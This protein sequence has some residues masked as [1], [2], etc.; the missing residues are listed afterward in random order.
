[1]SGATKDRHGHGRRRRLGALLLV[2]LAGCAS[3][4]RPLTTPTADADARARLRATEEQLARLEQERSQSAAELA[5]LEKRV[6]GQREIETVLEE[7]VDNL[8]KEND[9]LHGEL[10]GVVMGASATRS[11][12]PGLVNAGGSVDPLAL[13]RDLEDRLRRFTEKYTAARFDPSENVCRFASDTLFRDGGDELTATGR[14]MLEELAQI[15]NQ[16]SAKKFNLSIVGHTAVGGPLP[17]RLVAQHPTEWHLA[18]HQ[19]IAVG[20][21]LEESGVAAGRIGVISYGSQQPVA[22]ARTARARGDARVEVFL[23]PPALSN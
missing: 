11:A 1:M 2:G 6:D 9:R 20:Q 3:L 7:R 14:M 19:A 4:G 5:A 15:V 22:G 8:R 21:V 10:T 16:T 23:V 12:E 17:A 13:P 18:A